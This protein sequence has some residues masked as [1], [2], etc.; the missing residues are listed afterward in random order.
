MPDAVC[1]AFLAVIQEYLPIGEDGAPEWR[2]LKGMRVAVA[3]DAQS[4]M[5][6]VAKRPPPHPM[7]A[8]PLVY[9]LSSAVWGAATFTGSSFFDFSHD[10]ERAT[11][12]VRP[13]PRTDERP[14]PVSCPQ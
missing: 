11:Y 7:R 3:A 5:E 13:A 12:F 14:I 10:A 6:E 8:V 9:A 1:N 2:L 4:T